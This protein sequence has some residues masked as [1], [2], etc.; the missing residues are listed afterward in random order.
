[1]K[2]MY[3]LLKEKWDNIWS[4]PENKFLVPFTFEDGYPGWLKVLTDQSYNF[5]SGQKD[6]IREKFREYE[7]N[8][9]IKLVEWPT[10]DGLKADDNRIVIKNGGSCNAM[11]GRRGEAA[12]KEQPL[13][14]Q[15]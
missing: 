8:T 2:A 14:L 12:L 4:G 5:I 7:Q 3:L 1:M 9:C 15:E 11:I 13:I 6:V 10:R